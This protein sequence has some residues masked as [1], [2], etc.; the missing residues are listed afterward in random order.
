MKMT[1]Q[2]LANPGMFNFI[3]IL[4]VGVFSSS[5]LPFIYIHSHFH[6]HVYN[7]NPMNVLSCRRA[8]LFHLL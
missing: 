7:Y 6:V 5:S 2:R 1:G 8:C 3:I 4:C